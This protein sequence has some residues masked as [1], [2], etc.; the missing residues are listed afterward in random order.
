MSPFTAPLALPAYPDAVFYFMSAL[1]TPLEFS[2]W[3]AESLSWK[4]GCYIHAGLS[5]PNETTFSGSDA[6]AFLS[7]LVINGFNNFRPG[8]AK[9]AIMLNE[10]ALV[11]AHGVLQK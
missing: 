11:M 10:D 6:E 1:P 4:K 3:K 9:H 7:G 8:V 2:G 5:G